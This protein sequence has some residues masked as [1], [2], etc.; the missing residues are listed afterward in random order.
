MKKLLTEP[1][2]SPMRSTGKASHVFLAPLAAEIGPKMEGSA[3][4]GPVGQ[5]AHTALH[6]G[7]MVSRTPAPEAI[8][9]RR[10]RPRVDEDKAHKGNGGMAGAEAS[11]NLRVSLARFMAIDA[12]ACYLL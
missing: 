6:K 10:H 12:L 1:K 8:P 2:P 4:G 7:S 3:M 5:P 11:G 9:R